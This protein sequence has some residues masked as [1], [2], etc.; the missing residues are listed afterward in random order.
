M[1][2]ELKVDNFRLNVF[3]SYIFPT[4]KHIIAYPNKGC[5]GT[6][7]LVHP[8]LK[9]VNSGAITRGLVWV[10]INLAQE[11]IHLASVYAPNTYT[12]RISL[13]KA[14]YS[15]ASLGKWLIAGDYNMV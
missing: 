9:I 1:L 7:I 13:W 2:Q 4:Y 14:L 3:L 8:S 5:G 11:E 6:A 12:D 10:S 15:A